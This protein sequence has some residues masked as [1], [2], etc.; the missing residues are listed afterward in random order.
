MRGKLMAFLVC[1][2]I[3]G[4]LWLTHSLNSQ[5][6]YA[7]SVPVR[8]VNLPNNKILLGSLP[9]N[10]RFDVK[11]S[12]LKLFFILLNKPFRELTID[13]NALKGDNK[14]Q[15]YALSSGN[16]DL[17][18]SIKFSVEI[19][20]ISPDTLFFNTK[21][22]LS[23]NVP[24]RPLLYLVPDKGFV[25]SKPLINPSFITISG[26]SGLVQSIDSIPTMPLYLSQVS[27]S[28]N[29]RLA[30]VRPSENIYLNLNEVS[31]SF[32]ADKLVEKE[33]DL[34]IEITNAPDG[35]HIKLFPGQARIRFSVA[36]NDFSDI[37]D[38]SFKAI[39]NFKKTKK[40]YNKLPVELTVIPTQAHILSITPPEAEFLIYKK[41]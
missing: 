6:N 10:I 15:A 33:I 30:L 22:G 7:L 38:R 14:S 3:S 40:G 9:E 27:K 37:N 24:V 5:Y 35:G 2:V 39:V 21:K 36:Y 4:F 26:D 1:L 12:G 8:F 29:G 16:I 25:I 34:P 13:F 11:A 20:K 32:T 23:K 19:K 18:S 28:Y 41:K 31:V 17:S